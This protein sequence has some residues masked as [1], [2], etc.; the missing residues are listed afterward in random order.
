MRSSGTS[1]HCP[2]ELTP[3]LCGKTFSSRNASSYTTRC[4]TSNKCISGELPAP[5][6]EKLTSLKWWTTASKHS[7]ASCRS[8]ASRQAVKTCSGLPKDIPTNVLSHCAAQGLF[9]DF[10]T[11]RFQGNVSKF[12]QA[13]PTNFGLHQTA[14]CRIKFHLLRKFGPCSNS[15]LFACKT[16]VMR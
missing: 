14:E 13:F 16:R 9:C 6:P 5:L 10:R 7:N 2:T 15:F 1:L 8:P 12:S 4:A 3:V 11:I